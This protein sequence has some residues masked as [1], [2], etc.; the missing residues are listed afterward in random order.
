M[1]PCHWVLSLPLPPLAPVGIYHNTN[2]TCI[3]LEP[4]NR[5]LS[6]QSSN[7]A[8]F[9]FS[10]SR[11]SLP[12]FAR[13]DFNTFISNAW[14][15]PAVLLLSAS[16]SPP[17]LPPHSPLTPASLQCEMRL[18]RHIIAARLHMLHVVLPVQDLPTFQRLS[19]SHVAQITCGMSY[20]ET[21][22]FIHRDLRAANIL[23]GDN[24]QVKV[25]DFGLAR[26]LDHQDSEDD[27]DVYLATEGT[28]AINISHT[29]FTSSHI[30]S[31]SSRPSPLQHF[32]LFRSFSLPH[33]LSISCTPST[34]SNSTFILSRLV[35][36]LTPRLLTP[37]LLTPRLLTPRLLTL[38]LLTPRLIQTLQQS[39]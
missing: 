19:L 1:W 36:H 37:R 38:R 21:E 23:V 24:H 28:Q 13:I 7:I 15:S 3:L 5:L 25:A 11:C 29:H 32:P 6:Q 8:W 34:P 10:F 9:I 14:L 30:S 17:S 39:D 2:N 12:L 20:L 16:L 26:A 18:I 35:S 4:H 27:D 33:P 31:S 22:N